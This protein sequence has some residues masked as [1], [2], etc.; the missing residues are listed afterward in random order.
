MARD[1]SSTTGKQKRMAE[2][3]ED[4]AIKNPRGSKRKAPGRGKAIST[5]AARNG[6]R[7]SG[8]RKASGSTTRK[9]AAKSTVAAK[10]SRKIV[11][12][13][14]DGPAKIAA[15]RSKTAARKKMV[16]SKTKRTTKKTSISKP[17]DG[18]GSRS[19]LARLL[20]F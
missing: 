8:K 9:T 10:S 17:A 3:I 12:P 4:R 18:R 11:K 1:K 14:A 7:I 6:G 19:L 15:S 16:G 13:K 20:P 2:H 5:L